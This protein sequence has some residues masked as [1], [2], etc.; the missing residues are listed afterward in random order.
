MNRSNHQRVMKKRTL[1]LAIAVAF[2]LCGLAILVSSVAAIIPDYL[3][4]G[5]T[6]DQ[7]RDYIQWNGSVSY[8]SLY[9]RD[10]TSLPPSEGGSSCANGCTET[11]T[12]IQN[13]SSISGNFTFLNTFNIQA[14]M[15]GDRNVGTVVVRACGQVIASQNLY[16]SGAGS[17][18]FNNYPSPAWSVPTAGDC[19]WSITASGGY[20]DIRAVTTTYR[21]TAIPTVDLKVNNTNGPVSQSIPGNYTLS[22]T[23]TNAAG[24]SASGSWSGSKGISGSQAISNVAAG[25]YTYVLTC[26]NPNGSASD[27]VTAYVYGS[28][29]VDVQINNQN[30]PLTFIEPASFTVTWSS[31]NASTCQAE[32]NLTGPIGLSG[33][34]PVSGLPQ[35]NYAYT[36]R[37][38]N[39]LG[40][41]AIDT[42]N[43]SVHPSPPTVDLRVDNQNGP[44]TRVSPASYTLTW[45]SQNAATCTAS[46]TDGGWSGS[47]AVAG[48][49]AFSGVGV[50]THTYTV[51]CANIS[52]S[53]VDSVTAVVVAPLS[54][55]V[56]ALYARLVLF[57][58][59]L[60]QPAQTLTGAASGGEPPYQIT[61]HIRSPFGIETTY[62]K[63]GANWTLDP[64]GSGDTTLGVTEEGGWTAWATLRDSANRTLTT[65]SAIWEVSWYPVHGRP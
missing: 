21:S 63:S 6:F 13:G 25:T 43:V 51:T 22:W 38:S 4:S 57:A 39:P 14:A 54:G 37:C 52:G 16:T 9:H 11:V 59:A 36:V 46:S 64:S 42:V 20:V 35:G 33:A 29:T 32:G 41:Q 5:R 56:S 58:P 15:T 17:A 24:C 7:E 61:V 65:S 62:S 49:K 44:I 27:S 26:T 60:G 47:V 55:S 23:S 48:T 30:G 34:K 10:N 12:R 45:S 40:A 3:K 31:V 2:A 19:T 8:V 28:P 18:G 1:Q 53:A 50:G